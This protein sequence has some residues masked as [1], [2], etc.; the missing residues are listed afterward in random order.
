[1]DAINHIDTE[2]GKQ[3]IYTDILNTLFFKGINETELL[4]SN[5]L[6]ITEYCI[7]LDLPITKERLSKEYEPGE[8]AD[9]LLIACKFKRL[10]IIQQLLQ[11]KNLDGNDRIRGTIFLKE[12]CKISKEWFKDWRKHIDLRKKYLFTA[13]QAVGRAFRTDPPL[14]IDI[15]DDLI[16]HTSEKW[17]IKD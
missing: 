14:I 15:N 16:K 4:C 8:L 3:Y 9:F 1:M 17:R 2:Y 12:N 6:M 10:S 11:N 7:I 5:H 13:T